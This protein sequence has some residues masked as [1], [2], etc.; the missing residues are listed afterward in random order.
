[1]EK[2]IFLILAVPILIFVF[3][4]GGSAIMTGFKAKVENAPD[5]NNEDYVKDNSNSLEN[6]KNLSNEIVKLNELLKAR[7]ITQEEFEKAKNKLLNN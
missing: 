1:M 6:S 7:I 2:L 3:Y 5:K 4:L